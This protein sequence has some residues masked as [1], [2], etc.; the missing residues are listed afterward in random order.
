MTCLR[1]SRLATTVL[2]IAAGLSC[3][4]ND[5]SSN[6]SPTAPGSTN[7]GS[8]S[9][10]TSNA[11]RTYP[12]TT[13]IRT[14]TSGISIEFTAAQTASFDTSTKK[15]TVQTSS[16]SA[17]VCTTTNVITYN[18]VADFVDEVRVIPPISLFASSVG[19][20]SGACPAGTGTTVNIYDAQRR[21]VQITDGTKAVT[22]YTAWDSSGR[23]TA[24]TTTGGGTL[25]LAY[26]DG[27]RTVTT[28][29]TAADGTRS[30]T[31]QTFDANGAMISQV[32]NVSGFTTTTTFTNTATA[33]ACK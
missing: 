26:D 30:V 27:A 31:T 3:S 10:S 32:L 22:T 4:N 15:A 6:G 28:T 29:G 25:T 1:F 12:T 7:A 17:P 19:T 20:N 5:T 18:S 33:Q 13:N 9:G 11:C 16:T 21:V 14:T 8:G 24:G 23:P 2:L